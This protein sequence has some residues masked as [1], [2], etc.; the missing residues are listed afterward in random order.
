MA[1]G[2]A[3]PGHRR[4]FRSLQLDGEGESGPKE[5]VLRPR[6]PQSPREPPLSLLTPVR[7]RSF[8]GTPTLL[9]V[10]WPRPSCGGLPLPHTSGWQH[11]P[12][13][14]AVESSGSLPD[15]FTRFPARVCTRTYRHTHMHA[16]GESHIHC[17]AEP[18]GGVPVP[19]SRHRAV[20]PALPGPRCAP[21]GLLVL[22]LSSRPAPDPGDRV[23]CS[24][25]S[26]FILWTISAFSLLGFLGGP[27]GVIHVSHP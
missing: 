15:T 19:S 6:A 20:L 10:T 3:L 18:R 25:P 4:T 26:G 24:P 1:A 5:G 16:H 7:P 21:S 14:H 13:G 27:W 22:P 17:A 2:R 8:T 9:N 23:L 12:R 11:E